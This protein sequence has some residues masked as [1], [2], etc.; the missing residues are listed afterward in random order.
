M[1][2][3][4]GIGDNLYIA[5]YDLSG[6]VGEITRVASPRGSYE[7]TGINTA[8]GTERQLTHTDGAIDFRSFFNDATGQEHVALKA[9]GSGADRL[10]M[11]THG[12]A[13]GNPAAMLSA[14]QVNYDGDRGADGSLTLDVQAL[15]AAGIG[16]E[17]GVLLTAG[18]ETIPSAAT[19]GSQNNGAA[20]ANGL[21]A[22]L[23]LFDIASGTPVITIE[24]SSDDG[25][26]DAYTTKITFTSVA[27]G[28]EP[29]AERKT[30]SGAVEQYLRVRGGGTFTNAV[31]AVAVR[32]GTAQDDAPYS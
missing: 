21:A 25:G 16:L 17:W 4:S 2:K 12:T 30:V 11:A 6:D 19:L 31:V 28:S 27:D 14:K 13:R 20:T 24:E 15:A 8:G 9:K 26:A 3:S 10:V 23:Q 32:R 5:G 29:A 22:Q 7:N 1:S 18:K